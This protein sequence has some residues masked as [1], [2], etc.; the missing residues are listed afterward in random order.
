MFLTLATH[1]SDLLSFWHAITLGIIQGITEFL[2][3]SSTG[4]MILINYLFQPNTNNASW[5][6]S[7]NTY[8][9]CI[10]LGTI[11]ALILFFRHEII[12]M[13][14][15]LL[16]KNKAGLR[17]G[18]NLCIAFIPAGA[19]GFFCGDWIQSHLYGKSSLIYSVLAGAFLIFYLHYYT[20]KT[21]HKYDQLDQITTRMAIGIGLWQIVALW[22]GFSRSLATIAG[23]IFVGLSLTKAIQFSFL[24]GLLTSSVACG[25]KGLK[26]G[27]EMLQ[28]LD[29]T[30]ITAGIIVA[31][32][33]G[34]SSIQFL[35]LCL[36]RYGLKPF[37]YY[38]CVLA[39][40]LMIF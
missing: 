38:R 35:L 36:K 34:L 24:L 37:G 2:P 39:L 21:P 5:E 33:V 20:Q 32:I 17:L 30:S 25:Y 19:C 28:T 3:V 16:G 14:Q 27:A 12:Q 22:P 7:L 40:L 18:I 11:V 23:G 1:Q 26:H 15:G 10:Q 31:T 8:M 9:V 6:Q 29:M 13:I 4:H